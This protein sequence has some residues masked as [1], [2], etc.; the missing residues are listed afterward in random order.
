MKK[1]LYGFMVTVCSVGILVGCSAQADNGAL[2]ST[3]QESVGE[4]NTLN[5]Q[6]TG[7]DEETSET[8]T[9]TEQQQETDDK[10]ADYLA[11][12][13]KNSPEGIEYFPF[14]GW[15][16]QYE[17]EGTVIFVND[18][19]STYNVCPRM[20]FTL[21]ED[22]TVHFK[23][24][25]KTGE[26]LGMLEI[27]SWY[28]PEGE[29]WSRHYGQYG[30]AETEDTVF[31]CDLEFEKGTYEIDFITWLPSELKMEVSIPSGKEVMDCLVTTTQEV[32]FG[33]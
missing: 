16:N 21:S 33:S 29:I 8:Q 25:S 32:G 3:L 6:E 26:S 23:M 24:T 27:C 1:I 30:S 14:S 13:P 2:D 10:L 18:G 12:R 20:D 28:W 31:E 9:E 22:T 11:Q 17:F 15:T 4:A 5:P 19:N 7:T